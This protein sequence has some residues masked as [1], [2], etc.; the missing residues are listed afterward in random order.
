MPTDCRAGAEALRDEARDG[1]GVPVELPLIASDANGDALTLRRKWTASGP[2][3]QC[4]DRPHL[5]VTCPG[6]RR[7]V[8]GSGGGVRRAPLSQSIV[9]VDGHTCNSSLRF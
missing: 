2:D 6:R 7:R 8:S 1:A 9:P 5:R 3:D 4:V